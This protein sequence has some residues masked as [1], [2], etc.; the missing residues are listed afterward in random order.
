LLGCV[1]LREFSPPALGTREALVSKQ[2]GPFPIRIARVGDLGPNR[3]LIARR[4]LAG[5]LS[6]KDRAARCPTL[7]RCRRVMSSRPP[8]GPAVNEG[9]ESTGRALG[10]RPDSPGRLSLRTKGAVWLDQPGPQKDPPGV[11]FLMKRGGPLAGAGTPSTTPA[12]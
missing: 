4:N 6:G 11:P 12:F 3:N 7:K 8:V 10:E 2:P 5:H 1:P 9:P